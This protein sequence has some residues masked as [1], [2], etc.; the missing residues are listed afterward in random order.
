[1]AKRKMSYIVWLIVLAGLYIIFKN[2]LF[3][4]LFFSAV[5]MLAVSIVV[6]KILI[7]AITVRVEVD[8]FKIIR[9]DNVKCSIHM[10]N[11]TIFPTNKLYAKIRVHNN[12]FED[13]EEFYINVPILM[14]KE[15]TVSFDIK[16]EYVGNVEIEVSEIILKDYL[17]VISNTKKVSA[18]IDIKVMPQDI[19]YIVPMEST[20]DEDDEGDKQVHTLDSTELRGVREYRDG[21]SLHRIHWKLSTKFDELM[22]KE[23]EKSL[24]ANTTILLDLIKNRYEHINDAIEVLNSIL[25]G[26]VG[27]VSKGCTVNWYDSSRDDYMYYEVYNMEDIDTLMEYIYETN[28]GGQSGLVYYA[29]T[30]KNDVVGTANSI[31]I[32]D[33]FNKQV[34]NVI[35]VYD[36]KVVLKCV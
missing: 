21:E 12:F 33:K 3:G 29:Y 32:T 30:I 5:V 9:D 22:V 26:L 24:E 34:G 15:N 36:D 13:Q 35:G 2:T 8:T 23:F 18:A 6:S 25:V 4:V 1:M 28:L 10:L 14:R 19:N 7:K 31:L 27:K 20:Y 17:E 11:N 16:C